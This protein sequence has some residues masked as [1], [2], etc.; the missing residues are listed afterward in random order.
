MHVMSP[1]SND[2]ESE[3]LQTKPWS[4]LN[5]DKPERGPADNTNTIIYIINKETLTTKIQ[6]DAVQG[7]LS[8]S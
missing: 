2:K 8:L 1:K 5:H 3:K 4:K 7:S 6:L